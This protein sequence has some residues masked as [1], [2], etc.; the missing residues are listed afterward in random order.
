MLTMV[1][2][3]IAAFHKTVVWQYCYS[4]LYLHSSRGRTVAG[5]CGA[6]DDGPRQA[7][8]ELSA[9]AVCLF[10]NDFAAVIMRYRVNGIRSSI[11][12][13]AFERHPVSS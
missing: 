8:C 2:I 6:I 12:S 9:G 7:S 11:S 5:K 3:G 10:Y 1:A 13:Q 4:S